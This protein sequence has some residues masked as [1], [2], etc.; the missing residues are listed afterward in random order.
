MRNAGLALMAAIILLIGPSRIWMGQHWASDVL[1]GYTL[2]FGLLL[3]VIWG[4]RGWLAR[5]ARTAPRAAGPARTEAR[6]GHE[7]PGT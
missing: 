6:S 5:L 4:Y 2:A 3:L 7:A 1:G